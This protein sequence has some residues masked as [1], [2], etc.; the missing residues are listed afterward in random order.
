MTVC[1]WL[2]SWGLWQ[3]GRSLPSSCKD[4][5]V[6]STSNGCLFPLDLQLM[7]RTSG[8]WE[9]PLRNLLTI[10]VRFPLINFQFLKMYSFICCMC[11]KYLLSVLCLS[12]FLMVFFHETPPPQFFYD[13]VVRLYSFHHCFHILCFV[14]KILLHL[15]VF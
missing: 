8:A 3:G 12:T 14:F 5:K 2:D 1:H 6:V 11:H 7:S 13:N 9:L 15:K 10:L 4:H